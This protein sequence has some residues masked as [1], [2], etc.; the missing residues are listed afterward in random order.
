MFQILTV[1]AIW[2]QESR[3]SFFEGYTVL[4]AVALC[5]P[6]IPVEHQLCIYNIKA[7]HK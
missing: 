4:K 2:I 1:K 6:G 7:M 3:S 5:L